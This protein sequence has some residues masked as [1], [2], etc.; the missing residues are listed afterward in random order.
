MYSLVL[1]LNVFVLEA[2]RNRSDVHAHKGPNLYA[3]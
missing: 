2:L 3:L 1:L